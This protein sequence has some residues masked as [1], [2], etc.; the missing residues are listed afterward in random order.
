M[1]NPLRIIGIN[2]RLNANIIPTS[3]CSLTVMPEINDEMPNIAKIL[4]MLLLIIFPTLRSACRYE[5]KIEN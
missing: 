1:T 2:T 5:Q 4:N 3:T